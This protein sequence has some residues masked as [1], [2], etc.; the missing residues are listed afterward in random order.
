MNLYLLV[1]I[2]GAVALIYG[3]YAS[4]AVLSAPV[5]NERM[6]EIAAAIQEGA[7]AFLN[8]QYSAIAIVGVIIGV[9][10]GLKLG[11]HGSPRAHTFAK[12]SQGTKFQY[13][14]GPGA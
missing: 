5:G 13:K 12:R 8:R 10:L 6:Q 3:I 11:R 2:C 7:K 9:L 4:K 1:I 14:I